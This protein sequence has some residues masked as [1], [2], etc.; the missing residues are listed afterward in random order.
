MLTC[1]FCVLQAAT[2]RAVLDVT[3]MELWILPI[4]YYVPTSSSYVIQYC[5][6]HASRRCVAL[7]FRGRESLDGYLNVK[8]VE[9]TLHTP[10]AKA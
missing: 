10:L 8:S 9:V 3:G 1:D 4:Q 2:R 6:I 5:G 7:L